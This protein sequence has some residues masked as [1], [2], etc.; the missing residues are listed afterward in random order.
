MSDNIGRKPHVSSIVEGS[1][2]FGTRLFSEISKAQEVNTVFSGFSVSVLLSLASLGAKENTLKQIKEAL[3]LPNEPETLKSAFYDI[4]SATKSDER[5]TLETANS[6]FPSVGLSDFKED[7]SKEAE[8]IFGSQI[9]AL[10]YS[11]K[12]EA[13]EA[14][15][16]W[17]EKSTKGCI[18]ELLDADSLGEDTR[19]VLVNSIY[20]KGSWSTKFDSSLTEEKDFHVTP[21]KIVKV[22]TMHAPKI[23]FASSFN[24]DLN[25]T[26]LALPYEGER[27]TMYFLLPKEPF[28]LS[29]LEQKLASFNPSLLDKVNNS[30]QGL[31]QIPKFKIESLHDLGDAVGSL[32]L[33][34]L[35]GE[36]CDLSGIGG[37]PGEL[38]VSK[39]I[40]KACLEVNEEG[41]EASA[42]TGLLIMMRSVFVSGPMVVDHPFAFMI[43]DKATGMILFQGKVVD[44]LL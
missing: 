7:F 35:F 2:R 29:E 30:V 40:Q 28:G 17:V 3:Q 33:T 11:K 37:Q 9:S 13:S 12:L 6:V 1:T 36:G 14:I 15:N 20:F 26:I 43:R 44:P 34:D 10:D 31:V 25:A 42:S 38:S 19:A 32:G 8:K 39:M 23:R 21:D 24:D 16:V 4:N 18:R 27:M 41:S 5:I 22:P